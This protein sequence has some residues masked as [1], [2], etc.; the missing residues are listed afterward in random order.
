MTIV[1]RIPDSDYPYMFQAADSASLAGQNS[2]VETT[3]WRL[4]LLSFAALLG[5]FSWQFSW[6]EVGPIDALALTG[7]AAFIATLMLELNTWR[8]RPDKS[9]YDGRAVAESAKTLTW[10]FAAGGN[11]FP[12]DMG[13]DDAQRALLAR[14]QSV[15][16]DFPELVLSPLNAPAISDW[17]IEQRQSTFDD[18][19]KSYLAARINDQKNWYT[20]NAKL[21]KRRSK[22]WRFTLLSL[23]ILGAALSLASAFNQ[24]VTQLSSAIAAF[25]T[26]IVAWNQTKQHDFNARAYSAAIHD[27]TSA[28]AKLRLVVTEESWA[29]EVDDAEEAISREHVVWLA[30]RSR[31]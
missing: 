13:V 29:R 20:D 7:A 16:N 30:T 11:P 28:E 10:K 5:L 14:L 17:M 2:Y 4:I 15:K 26:A 31:L 6:G 27:L 23:E 3:R 24:D 8:T 22:Q 9:W 25:L 1:D 19:K 21:N 18:R 12:I